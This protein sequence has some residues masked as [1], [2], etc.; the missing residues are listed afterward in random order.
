M[1][2][3]FRTKNST[4]SF[5]SR[6]YARLRIEVVVISLVMVFTV[7]YISAILGML[8]HVSSESCSVKI[9]ESACGVFCSIRSYLGVKCGPLNLNEIG[10]YLAGSLSPIAIFW[11]AVAFVWQ[12]REL[13]LQRKEYTKNIDILE[14]QLR[15]QKEQFDSENESRQFNNDNVRKLHVEGMAVQF[16]NVANVLKS[17]TSEPERVNNLDD[18]ASFVLF[19]NRE[20][21]TTKDPRLRIEYAKVRGTMYS[22]ACLG[23]TMSALSNEGNTLSY[24]GIPD[25][26][27]QKLSE[28]AKLKAAYSAYS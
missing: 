4:I 13:S 11:F 23:S 6:V 26:V 22:L 28:V 3:I 14:Q 10:D 19:F 20:I 27:L 25:D 5:L 2:L 24:L 9:P 17:N 8:V 21:A 15:H 1:S 18:A 16:I 7:V 12:A